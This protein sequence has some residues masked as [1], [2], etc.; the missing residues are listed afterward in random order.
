V[1]AGDFKEARRWLDRA[2]AIDRENSRVKQ[3]AAALQ[4]ADKGSS[5]GIG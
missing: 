2:A 4:S 3:L 5:G 1:A